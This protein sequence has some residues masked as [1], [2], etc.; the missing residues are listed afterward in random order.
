MLHA[1]V[2]EQLEGGGRQRHQSIG[3]FI[4]TARQGVSDRVRRAG[5]VLHMEIKS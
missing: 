1:Q 3:R 4:V 2:F 5:L